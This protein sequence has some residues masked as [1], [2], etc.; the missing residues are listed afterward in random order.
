[1]SEIEFV[2]EKVQKMEFYL[3]DVKEKIKKHLIEFQCSP[4]SLLQED[5]PSI[6]AS[7]DF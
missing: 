7:K 1:M 4:D 5:E 6:I 3:K 2:N